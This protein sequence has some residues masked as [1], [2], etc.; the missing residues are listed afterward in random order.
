M[1]R[2]H[3]RGRGMESGITA[4]Y[5]Q[6]LNDY[7]DDW[8]APFDLCP[9]LTIPADDLDFVKKP[10]HLRTIIQKVQD[11]LVGKEEVVFGPGE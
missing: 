10:R 2:I 7:Y 1:A 4:D 5:L 6:L 3:G 11:K 8:L 9:V